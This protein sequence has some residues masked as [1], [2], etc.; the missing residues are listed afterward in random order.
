MA[1]Q[2]Q[3]AQAEVLGATAILARLPLVPAVVEAVLVLVE[4][5]GRIHSDS[6]LSQASRRHAGWCTLLLRG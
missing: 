4:F 6:R 1:G 2:G 5:P 3:G